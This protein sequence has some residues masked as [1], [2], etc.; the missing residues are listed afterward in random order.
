MVQGL[1]GELRLW[2]RLTWA[3]GGRGV[4]H[5]Q[6]PWEGGGAVGTHLGRFAGCRGGGICGAEAM[7]QGG[8][9]G[10]EVE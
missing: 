7:G 4:S 9:G 6:N 8:N 2:G 1:W 10:V 3:G 5:G